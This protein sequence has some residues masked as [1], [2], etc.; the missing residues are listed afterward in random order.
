MIGRVQRNE[1][2]VT[3]VELAVV[4]L[5]MSIIAVI[6]MTFMATMLR[7]T[8]RTA[9]STEA[10]KQTAL[11]LRPMTANLRGS[12]TIATAYPATTSCPA[13]TYPTGYANCLS[14]TV[15]RP[16][17]GQLS[18]RRSVY[19]YGLKSDGVLREDRTDYA[20]VG[21]SCVVTR[22][23]AGLKLL[24]NV[25]NG[26]QPLFT[27]FDRFGNQLDPNASGQ[28]AIPFTDA[29]TIRVALN[30]QYQSG[31]PLLSYTSDLALRNNR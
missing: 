29:V 20:L 14:V 2:G 26:S 9:N 13:G 8:T 3:I 23:D 25:K 18:C 5:L 7:T 30:V 10:Q 6:L 12:V 16:I 15:M 24:S 28:T 11:A 4:L 22:N 27:Y 1:D 19:S 31:S 17:P 21:G